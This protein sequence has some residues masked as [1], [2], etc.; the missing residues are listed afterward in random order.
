MLQKRS[1]ASCVPSR[2]FPIKPAPPFRCHTLKMDAFRTPPGYFESLADRTVARRQVR[3]R[4]LRATWT[5]A[6]AFAAGWAFFALTPFGGEDAPACV[7]FA[8]L[9]DA[10]STEELL[11][12][13]LLEELAEDPAAFD[14]LTEDL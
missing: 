3:I 4:R 11:H 14:V 1:A 13:D 5:A 9:L 12:D 10:T 2:I 6:A 8:C 7:T